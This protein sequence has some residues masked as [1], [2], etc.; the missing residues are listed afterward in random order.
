[1]S[2]PDPV[3]AARRAVAGWFPEAL[4][5]WLGGSAAYG[6]PTPTSD[7]D[8]TVLLAGPPA[9][10]RDSRRF[11]GWPVELFVHT[12]A[13]LAHYRAKDLARR[14][15]TMLRLV[16]ESVLLVDVDGSGAALQADW[17]G[18]LAA[19]PPALTASEVQ[20]QRYRIS[21]LLDDLAGVVDP[22]ERTAIATALWGAALRLLLAGSGRWLGTGK[23]LVREVVALDAAAGTQEAAWFDHALR[24]ALAGE[25]APLVQAA[26]RVLDRHGGRLFEGYR[27]GGE[28]GAEPGAGPAPS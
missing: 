15:P 6:A 23:G 8:I 2:L 24:A 7:L 18:Q 27:V 22:V 14:Q 21:D 17:R 19:G 20:S 26:D 28:P 1:M 10:Y 5:A 11:D 3:D 9:P 25:V 16:G 13:S 12:A 4:A